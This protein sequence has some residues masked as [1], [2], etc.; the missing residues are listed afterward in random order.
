MAPFR[1]LSFEQRVRIVL[2]NEEGVSERKTAERM[3]ISKTG[4]HNT[5]KRFKETGQYCDLLRPGQHR[6]IDEHGDCH[7]TRLYM[8][9]RKLTAPQ[10][11]RECNET[12][13]K[14]VCVRT[15]RNRLM[16]PELK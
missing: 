10:I 6:K 9:N 7:I 15:I 4:V 13:K 2:L 5:I 16:K 14:L 8:S 3:K 1:E 12:A 11:M